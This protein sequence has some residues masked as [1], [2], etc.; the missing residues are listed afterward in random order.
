MGFN[1][2][3][4]ICKFDQKCKKIRCKKNWLKK[5]KVDNS[6]NIVIRLSM[7]SIKPLKNSI[8]TLCHHLLCYQVIKHRCRHSCSQARLY[9]NLTFKL[10]PYTLEL[11]SR[12]IHHLL[13]KILPPTVLPRKAIG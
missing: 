2:N 10:I 1:S 13:M 12:V 11:G 7:S 8:F 5:Q 4:I 3:F 9:P 6:S